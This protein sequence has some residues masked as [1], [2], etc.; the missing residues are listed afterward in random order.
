[1]LDGMAEEASMIPTMVTAR[2]QDGVFVPTMP[3]DLVEGTDVDLAIVARPAAPA[4]DN[5]EVLLK[6]VSDAKTVREWR[7][8]VEALPPTSDGFDIVRE[9]DENRRFS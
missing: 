2:F 9:L 7:E 3:L 4:P 5:E 1:M 6:R 8:A